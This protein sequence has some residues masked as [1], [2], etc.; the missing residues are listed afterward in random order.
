VSGRGAEP[1]LM[2]RE[3]DDSQVDLEGRG[4]F[5]CFKENGM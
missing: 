1:V 4:E 2:D 3:M 5:F